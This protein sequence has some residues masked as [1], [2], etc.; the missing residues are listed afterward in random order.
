MMSR[1]ELLFLNGFFFLFHAVWMLFNMV[2]WVWRRTRPLHRV[3]MGLTAFSWFVLGIRY[4]LGY[5]ICT[6][7]HWRVREQL[8]Y[9]DPERSYTQLLIRSV[10]GLRISDVASQWLTGGI[11]AVAA[12]LAIGFA[13]SDRRC[14]ANKRDQADTDN[15]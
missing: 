10:T 4:G 12:V 5:C 9:V 8:G 2:G 15:D 7:W 1:F 11:F 6:H 14:L 3:T 13:I